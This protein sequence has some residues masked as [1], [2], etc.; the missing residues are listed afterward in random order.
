MSELCNHCNGELH[1]EEMV[2]SGEMQLPD[3]VLEELSIFT[4]CVTLKCKRAHLSETDPQKLS[5]CNAEEDA[6]GSSHA[7]SLACRAAA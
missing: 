1:D 4:G 3:C 6:V 7:T 2:C 5:Y